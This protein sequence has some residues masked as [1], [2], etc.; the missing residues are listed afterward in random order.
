MLVIPTVIS[1]NWE[2]RKKTIC[3]SS[4]KLFHY[5]KNIRSS[6]QYNSIC[7][8]QKQ[9]PDVFYKKAV[10]KNFAI[11]IG[12]QMRWTLFLITFPTQVFWRTSAVSDDYSEI[13][14]SNIMEKKTLAQVLWILEKSFGTVVLQNSCERLLLKY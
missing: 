6:I 5:D 1:N 3:R 7:T 11:F 8:M 4:N 9:P 14:V 12:K 2:K 10:L 13:L